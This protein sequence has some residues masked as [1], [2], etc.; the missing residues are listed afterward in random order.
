MIYYAKLTKQK[1]KGFLI[2]FPELPGCF[3]EARNRKVALKNAREALNG[4]LAARC[5][6]SLQIPTPVRHVERGFVPIKVD[7]NIAFAISLRRSRARLSLTQSEAAEKLGISQQA[8]AKVESAR[9][10]PSL[11]TIQKIIESLNLDIE[12]KLGS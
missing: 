8:Y 12:F 6:Y 4:W 1:H 10:N 5:N 11:A 3:T 9:A 2:E 7:L